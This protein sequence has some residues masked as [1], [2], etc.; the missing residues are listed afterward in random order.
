MRIDYSL[1]DTT[2][3]ERTRTSRSGATSRRRQLRRFPRLRTRT[4]TAARQLPLPRPAERRLALRAT[5]AVSC[6]SSR[7]DTPQTN[8]DTICSTNRASDTT[9]CGPA[10]FEGIRIF[11]LANPAQPQFLKGVYTDCGSHTHTLVPDL[12][13]NR[14]LLYVSSYPSSTGPHCQTP[15]REDLDRRGTAGRARDRERHRHA[16]RSTRRRSPGPVRLPRHHG[17][18]AIH[19]AAALVRR[20]QGQ[21]WDITDPANPDMQHPVHL[22]DSGVNFWHSA[23]F[24]WDGQY[25]V[26]RRRELHRTR[27]SQTTTGKIRI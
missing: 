8:G 23:E 17:F 5:T 10:C 6:S 21:I 26:I 11:D 25:V 7:I 4:R 14:V 15:A 19:K 12:A 20:P 22:R 24:T 18:L 16:A 2:R 9:A 13:N 1:N 27:A 3:G